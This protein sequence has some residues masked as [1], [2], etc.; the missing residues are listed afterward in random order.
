MYIRIRTGGVVYTVAVGK[1]IKWFFI[2]GKRI[3]NKKGHK[4]KES[5]MDAIETSDKSS[6]F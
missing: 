5:E 3:L 6:K 1:K 2:S 4:G